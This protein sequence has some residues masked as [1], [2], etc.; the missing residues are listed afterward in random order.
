MHVSEEAD[1]RV[2]FSGTA[3]TSSHEMPDM[4]AGNGTLVLWEK[5]Q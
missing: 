3:I 1:E 2:G 4:T 5:I